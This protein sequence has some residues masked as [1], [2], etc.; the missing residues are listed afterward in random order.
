M[1]TIHLGPRIPLQ[2]R[3]GKSLR[4]HGMTL[5]EVTASLVVLLILLG[6]VMSATLSTQ[7]VFVED[8]I[9]SR[10]QLRT[11][12]ALNRI[13]GLTSQALTTDTQFSTL[14]PSTGV[15]AHCLR[16][17]LVQGIDSTTGAVIYDD[18]AQVYILGPDGGAFPCSGVIIG[19]GPNL[20]TVSTVGGGTDGILG[21]TDDAVN[22]V[23]ASNMPV[24]E[25]L[26]PSTYAPQ[27]GTMLTVNLTPAPVGRLVTFTL[28]VNAQ[29]QNGSYVLANDLVLTES[30]ALW[31]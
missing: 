3:P 5:I 17:R 19:R 10:L 7:T 13:V 28:R 12:E 6:S 30:I 11:E 2:G 22:T 31:Q 29:N 9:V 27:S 20:S 23:V 1:N 24:V 25:L 4:E 18:A 15:S 21:T 16:F 26:L 8:Q 14:L